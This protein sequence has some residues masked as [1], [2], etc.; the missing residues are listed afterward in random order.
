MPP[1][2]A[3]LSLALWL[4]AKTQNLRPAAPNQILVSAPC[5]AIICTHALKVT[6]VRKERNKLLSF[7]NKDN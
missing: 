6:S 5:K 3:T 4:P 1:V 7:D 2:P